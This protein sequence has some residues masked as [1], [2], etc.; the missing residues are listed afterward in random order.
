VVD[1]EAVYQGLVVAEDIKTALLQPEAVPLLLVGELL[2][3]GVPTVRP[4]ETLDSVLDKF[5]RNHVQSL[6]VCARDDST[7]IEGLITRHGVM[8]RYQ[9]ELDRQAG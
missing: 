4:D 6:P 5:S 2:R 3:P 9:Q 8:S 1:N 7:R